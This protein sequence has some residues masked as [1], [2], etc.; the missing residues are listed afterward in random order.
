MATVKVD[1]WS[2]LIRSA[3]KSKIDTIIRE[4]TEIAKQKVTKKIGDLANIVALEI[5]KF[6]DIQKM[7]DHIVI[8]VKKPESE[9]NS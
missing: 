6:Y 9:E 2:V 7:Q 3:V 4:E 1:E 5:L 8:T